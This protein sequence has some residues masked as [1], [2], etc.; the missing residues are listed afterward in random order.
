M[1]SWRTLTFAPI[2]RRLV[3]PEMLSPGERDWLNSY[4]A[5]VYHKIAPCLS[6][7]AAKWLDAACAP[8]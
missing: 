7:S 8:L 4:H 5:E 3:V 2:D 6:A 1:L